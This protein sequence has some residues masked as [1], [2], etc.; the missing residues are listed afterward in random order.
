M[1]VLQPK[2]ELKGIKV[3]M[4]LSEETPAY[5]AKLYVDGKHFADL[6]NQGHVHG[7]RHRRNRGPCD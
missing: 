1:N 7:G 6:S 4:G 5:T 3:H 2:I